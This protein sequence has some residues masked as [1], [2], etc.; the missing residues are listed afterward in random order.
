MTKI[1]ICGIKREEDIEVINEVKPEFVGFVFWDKS[2]R[3]VSFDQAKK[4]RKLI[5]DKIK[6]VGVFVDRPIE[7]IEYL[8][9]EGIIS[10]AQLHGKETE[11]YISI[12]RKNIPDATIVKA[13]EVSSADDIDKAN[14]SNAD[15]VLIDSGKG[16]GATFDWKLLE[17]ITRDYMLAGGLDAENVGEA[18]SKLHPYAVDVSSKVETDGIKD[19]FKIR[20]FVNA[21]R[22]ANKLSAQEGEENK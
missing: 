15:M 21:V 9:K 12:L 8:V 20:N 17:K 1:K 19:S 4:L 16:S 5:D 18:V 11:E 10:V 22:V 14:T 6:T 7:D 2:K 3:N 13:F